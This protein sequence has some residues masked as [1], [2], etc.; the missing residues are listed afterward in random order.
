MERNA[1]TSQGRISKVAKIQRQN[2]TQ[3]NRYH[4]FTIEGMKIRLKNSRINKI[5][6]RRNLR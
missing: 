4:G 2:L 5:A 1:V 3:V 6:G